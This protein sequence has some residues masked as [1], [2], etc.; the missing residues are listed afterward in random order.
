MEVRKV[1]RTK[2]RKG[3][4]RNT[5]RLGIRKTKGVEEREGE[6]V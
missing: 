2:G 3:I 6:R 5:G 4:Q 1:R